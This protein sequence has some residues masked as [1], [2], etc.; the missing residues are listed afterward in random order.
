MGRVVSPKGLSCR[1]GPTPRT[2]FCHL[3]A[4]KKT[5]N[6]HLLLLQPCWLCVSISSDRGLRIKLL[7]AS[8]LRIEPPLWIEVRDP[9]AGMV[10]EETRREH[11]R[12]ATAHPRLWP[13]EEV[14]NRQRR[15]T[16]R[17]S[18][19]GWNDRGGRGVAV[20]CSAVEEER[21]HV[22]RGEEWLREADRASTSL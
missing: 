7:H 2:F 19:G 6:H 8:R 21:Q 11:G 15:A 17:R 16:Q 5:N 22:G 13:T 1:P 10:K 3:L 9:R 18:R 12:A 14:M 4:V 20:R